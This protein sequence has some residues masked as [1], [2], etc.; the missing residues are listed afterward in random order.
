MP[1]KI[2]RELLPFQPV[3]SRECAAG[4]LLNLIGRTTKQI[5]M[6]RLL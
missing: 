4:C 2:A 3:G 1:P 6:A 5:D